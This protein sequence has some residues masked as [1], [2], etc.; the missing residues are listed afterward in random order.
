M[1]PVGPGM[2]WAVA[3]L[4]E[5]FGDACTAVAAALAVDELNGSARLWVGCS[6]G[7]DSMVLLDA[8]AASVPAK[9][10]A[11]VHINHQLSSNADRWQQVIATRAE[12]LGCHFEAHT[13]A[14]QATGKG[15]EAAARQARY[16]VFESL[17]GEG[18]LLLLGHHADDQLE[19]LLYRL[20]RGAGLRGLAAM[21]ARR[22]LGRGALWRPLLN[23][24]RQTLEHYAARRQLSWVDDESNASEQFDRNYL[25]Q[26]VTPPLRQRWQQWHLPLART[27]AHLREGDLLLT[28]LATIDLQ[29]CGV[30]GENG[31]YSLSIALLEQLAPHRQRNMLRYWPERAVGVGLAS[32]AELDELYTAILGAR[33]D[34]QPQLCGQGYCWRRFAGRLYMLA[35]T[36]GNEPLAEYSL[37]WPLHTL[38]ARLSLPDGSVL[39]ATAAET[40]VGVEP[41]LRG[42]LKQL[43]VRPREPGVRSRPVGRQSSASIKNIFQ[44][45]AVAPW[46]RTSTPLLWSGEQLVAVGGLWIEADSAAPAGQAGIKI[47][48]N[49]PCQPFSE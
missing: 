32:T 7:L 15:V 3:E 8:L 34:A 21:P 45:Q 13:V 19:T 16:A 18:D 39:V 38:P 49:S 35:A 31:G 5:D 36:G 28:E 4:M 48:H 10:I 44:E 40:A 37:S 33:D 24:P 14:C 27:T 12:Q 1:T 2:N 41:L 9:R 29:S 6:G 20:L 17:L 25:R 22:S 11:V 30:R 43:S 23:L 42:D 26:Q 46:L 47:V